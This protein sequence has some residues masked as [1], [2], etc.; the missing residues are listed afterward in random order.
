MN[1]EQ[2]LQAAH[3]DL[4]IVTDQADLGKV[5]G[6]LSGFFSSCPY[7]GFVDQETDDPFSF[8]AEAA[9]VVTRASGNSSTSEVRRIARTPGRALTVPSIRLQVSTNLEWMLDAS[10]G[11]FTDLGSTLP[12]EHG[13]NL[14]NLVEQ[15]LLWAL[16]SAARHDG[17]V[18]TVKTDPRAAVALAAEELGEPCTVLASY[19]DAVKLLDS[20]RMALGVSQQGD[21]TLRRAMKPGLVIVVANRPKAVGFV[22][23]RRKPTTYSA[24]STVDI[25]VHTVG[26]YGFCAWA[27]APLSLIELPA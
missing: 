16:V 15:N 20:P 3:A 7:I 2:S 9:H 1:M 21:A 22:R 17:R 25:N 13:S 24:A 14:V 23:Q 27:N 19:L 11:C 26:Q 5:Y 6:S 12:D 18:I 8:G 4:H 10:S